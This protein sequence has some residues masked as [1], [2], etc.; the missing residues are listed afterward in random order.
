[1]WRDG[2]SDLLFA[3]D[4]RNSGHV[5]Q[6]WR[7]RTF[8]QKATLEEIAN[9]KVRQLPARDQS[10]DC[11]DVEGRDSALYKLIRRQFAPELYRPAVVP[12]TD[13]TC[14]AVKFQSRASKVTHFCVR[15]R[16]DSK[17][18]G[19]VDWKPVSSVDVET[20]VWPLLIGGRAHAGALRFK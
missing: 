19:R 13:G 14:V 7:L 6:W 4:A 16:V 11:T 3:Q 8:A 12:D 20:D 2:D 9:I 5:A 15:R 17:D 10:P 18:A 1:M